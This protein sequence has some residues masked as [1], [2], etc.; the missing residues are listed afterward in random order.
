MAEGR[1]ERGA[2]R[3]FEDLE[4]WQLSVESVEMVYR[5]SQRFPDSERF[6]LTAQ[7]RRAAV[8]VPSNIAEGFGRGS[9]QDY[10][11]FLRMAR[12]SLYEVETQLII[13]KRL[14]FTDEDSHQSIRAKLAETG[15]VRAGLI[16][17]IES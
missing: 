11:R 1:R 7:V 12:G 9:R 17:S 4:V 8:S 2:I 16:R 14:G 10:A 5:L 13:A 15:R 3:S 6:G